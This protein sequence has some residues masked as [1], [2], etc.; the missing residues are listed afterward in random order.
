M[1]LA[2]INIVNGTIVADPELKYLPNGTAV[3][4]LRVATNKRRKNEQSGQWENSKTH[5]ANFTAFDT[6]AENISNSV[7]KGDKIN[8]T[9]ELETQT[10]EK[11]GQKRN[12]D[13]ATVREIAIP[14][15]RFADDNRGGGQPQGDVWNSA[16]QQQQFGRNEPPF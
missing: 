5:Y 1:A 3:V 7:K 6:F 4:E 13:S 11:D 10:W 16:P 2:Q 12:K 15:P 8:I 9:G 14:I